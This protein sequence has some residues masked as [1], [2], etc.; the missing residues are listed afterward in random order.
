MDVIV[1]FGQVKQVAEKIW[2]EGNTFTTWA[3]HGSMGAGKT[4]F[5]HALCQVL[6]VR[7]AV[8]SPTFSIINEYETDV[9]G[10]VYHMDWYRLKD[11]HEAMNAGVE[12]YLLGPALCLVEW[13]DKA[14]GLLPDHTF[15]IHIE[16]LDE[17]TRR[18]FTGTLLVSDW[19]EQIQ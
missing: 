10:T 11:E 16:T 19:N 9:A 14:P 2:K 12:E 4:T 18:V 13:P 3:F 15:H 6:G 7:S 8:S 1:G 5:I 17:L